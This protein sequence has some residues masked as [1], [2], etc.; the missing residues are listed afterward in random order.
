MIAKCEQKDIAMCKIKRIPSEPNLQVLLN[1]IDIKNT[2]LYFVHF[3]WDWSVDQKTDINSVNNFQIIKDILANLDG[4]GFICHDLDVFLVI[5]P[6]PHKEI[7]QIHKELAK[8]LEISTE[9]F[10][11]SVYDTKIQ[12]DKIQKMCKSKIYD[13]NKTV[14]KI[15]AEKPKQKKNLTFSP[16]AL[17][18]IPKKREKS[19]AQILLVEDDPFS[20]HLVK[21]LLNSYCKVIEAETHIDALNAYV[22]YAPDLVFLDIDLPESTGYD[23]IKKLKEYDP[24]AFVVMLSGNAYMDNIKKSLELGAHSFIAKPFN[25]QSISDALKNCPH[26]QGKI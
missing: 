20:R 26:L 13:Y 12:Y 11:M 23:I 25:K 18:H 3:E 8:K 14:E 21:N 16:E 17:A 10:T 4:T 2:P 24:D 22:Q 6:K 5:R 15:P 1:T 19:P 7:R 9:D